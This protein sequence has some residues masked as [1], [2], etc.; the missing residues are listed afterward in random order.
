MKAAL[1]ILRLKALSWI[2]PACR[3]QWRCKPL[4]CCS[5]LFFN[6]CK[7]GGSALWDGN[8]MHINT[9]AHLWGSEG[10]TLRTS[11][12]GWKSYTWIKEWGCPCTHSQTHA[13]T[14]N[15]SYEELEAITVGATIGE[16]SGPTPMEAVTAPTWRVRQRYR[17]LRKLNKLEF[18]HYC[19]C[20]F[21]LNI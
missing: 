19:F 9:R 5:H 18:H 12:R 1:S 15:T 14:H 16:V 2:F 10:K 21:V 17:T 11:C 8:L 13:H 20:L 4:S 3:Q 6:V 7:K